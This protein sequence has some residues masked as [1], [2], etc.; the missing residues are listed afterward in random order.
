VNYSENIDFLKSQLE[1]TQ[2][3]LENDGQIRTPYV[4][5]MIIKGMID[6]E[7]QIEIFEELEKTR[8]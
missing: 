7:K 2:Q 5:T 1:Q 4:I 3:W 8:A 6:T